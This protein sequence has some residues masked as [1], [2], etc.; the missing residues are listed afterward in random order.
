MEN[1][2]FATDS[3]RSDHDRDDSA[4]AIGILSDETRLTILEALVPEY[5]DCPRQPEVSFSEVRDRTGLRDS[6]QFNYHLDKLAG[7]FVQETDA[8]YELNAAGQEVIGAVL[9][10]SFEPNGQWGPAELD[11]PCRECGETVAAHYEDGMI[12]VECDNGHLNHSDY[13]PGGIVERLS[14]PDAVELATLMGQQDLELQLR[15]VCPNCYGAIES[16]AA[17]EDGHPLLELRCHQCGHSFQGPVSLVV[18]THP[19]LQA[20]YFERGQDVRETPLWT[21]PFLT[22]RDRLRVR[23]ESPLR[24]EVDASDGDDELRFLI[25]ED[26]SV[27]EYHSDGLRPDRR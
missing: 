23:S 21:L 5:R 1:D 17:L 11:A 26:C 22:E 2:F 3:R 20:F 27:V 24:V 14:L 19:V 7:Q 25:D 18:L 12:A 8:G 13:F 16:G 9:S 6:G 4:D 15:E 10:G